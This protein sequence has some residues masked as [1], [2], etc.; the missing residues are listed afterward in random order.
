MTTSTKKNEAPEPIIQVSAERFLIASQFKAKNDIRYYLES[1]LIEKHPKKGAIIVGTDGHRMAVVYDPDAIYKDSEPRRIVK[2]NA[3]GLKYCKP[4]SGALSTHVCIYENERA[5]VMLGGGMELFVQPGKCFVEGVFPDYLK[6]V[7][8][9]ATL[10]HGVGQAFNPKLMDA[11]IKSA[12]LPSFRMRG[13]F[14]CI[15]TFIRD[16]DENGCGLMVI[17]HSNIDNAMFIVMPMRYDTVDAKAAFAFLPPLPK[18]EDTPKE[19][20]VKKEPAAAEG[21]AS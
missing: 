3:D 12:D 11:I 7:P 17:K 1:V 13:G 8:D 2:L 4:T 15:T 14:G 10:V 6:A 16:T 19:P 9:P 5:M 18:T 20:E 21:A